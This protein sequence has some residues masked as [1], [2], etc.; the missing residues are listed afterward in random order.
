MKEDDEYF[1][2]ELVESSFDDVSELSE[3]KR[4]QVAELQSL[5]HEVE[6][7]DYAEGTENLSERD[8]RM[9]KI[10]IAEFKRLGQ[11]KDREEILDEAEMLGGN[12]EALE[13]RFGDDV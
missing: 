11:N 3:E 13:E 1:I 10:L 9:M 7:S 6:L 8:A 4:E 5:Y 12:R 2:A